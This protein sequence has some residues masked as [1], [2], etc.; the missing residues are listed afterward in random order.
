LLYRW[1]QFIFTPDKFLNGIYIQPGEGE[2][3]SELMDE[4]RQNP[5]RK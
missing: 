2:D 4:F 5:E 3:V 1:K